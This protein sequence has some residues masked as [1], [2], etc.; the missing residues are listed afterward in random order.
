[1]VVGID[2]RAAAEEP[3]G[4]GRYVRELLRALAALGGDERYELWCREPWEDLGERFAW[5]VVGTR[6]P[7]WHAVVA[8]RA[9]RSCDAY[10]STNSYLTPWGLHTPCAIT[11]YDMIAFVHPEWVQARAGRIERATLGRGVRRAQALLCISE[12]T[13]RDL[14]ARE[15]GVAD[16]ACVVPL[17][18]GREF[19]ADGPS[20]PAGRPYVLAAGTLEP[21]K[22]LARLMDAWAALPD[23]AR[24]DHEL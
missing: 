15:P 22:N 19:V 13:R 3:A 8:R 18:A 12:A 4:G 5:R 17:G 7:L 20:P 9:S 10:L 1:M 24:G 16:R 21:R 6:D 11:V 2:A 23:R 14:V